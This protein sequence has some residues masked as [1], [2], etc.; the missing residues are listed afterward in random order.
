MKNV[1]DLFIVKDRTDI[2]WFT[3]ACASILCSAIYVKTVIAA[4]QKKPQYVIMDGTGVYYLAPSVEFEGAK[5]LH[6]A[7]TRLAMETLY[8]RTPQNLVFKNRIN[9]LFIGEGVEMVNNEFKT[10][11]KKF[12]EEERSQTI[13]VY[14]EPTIYKIDPRGQAI[15]HA[16]GRIIRHST[17]K[18]QKKTEVLYVDNYFYWKMNARMVDNILF[19]TA[20]FKMKLSDPAKEP[21]PA[22]S[23]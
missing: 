9:R 6:L 17:F 11:A 16:K 19:P 22:T 4:V 7:Q 20:C 23:S 10:D 8:T 1:V 5:E 13:D 21:K 12:V 15:T 2:F 18:G 14:E 3:M